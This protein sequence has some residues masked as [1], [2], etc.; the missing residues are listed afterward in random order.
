MSADFIPSNLEECFVALEKILSP[1]QLHQLRTCKKEDLALYHFGL[2]T[3]M[4]NTWRLWHNTPLAQDLVKR[5][6]KH[7]DDMSGFILEAFHKHLQS[8][9]EIKKTDADSKLEGIV[10]IKSK[11]CPL[12][13]AKNDLIF[14]KCWKCDFA[15]E[16]SGKLGIITE[17]AAAGQF[18]RL[19][20]TS[21]QD[22]WPKISK[23]LIDSHREKFVF[24]NGVGAKLDFAFAVIALE[25]EAV[26]N[27]FSAEQ[28]GR[29]YSWVLK[30]LDEPEWGEYSKREIMEY[31]KAFEKNILKGENPLD[32]ISARLLRKW[33]GNG[34]KNFEVHGLIAP[35]LIIQVS[36][37]LVPF[38]RFWKTIK[39]NYDLV[40]SDIPINIDIE[41]K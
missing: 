23:V 9:K 10:G 29:I 24:I 40:K 41:E 11:T 16:Q 33:L 1:E 2:G 17:S 35:L 27:L 7:P 15:F 39:D 25:L 26:S 36:S 37:L 38:V 34:I 30:G 6:V 4:R 5:G 31:Q 13:K 8:I 14:S 20:L 19:V 3:W 21:V 22:S 32:G 18:G 28:K 12:C